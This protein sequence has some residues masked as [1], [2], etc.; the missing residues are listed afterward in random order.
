VTGAARGIGRAAADALRKAGCKVVGLDRE[1]CDVVHDLTD[2]VNILS[3]IP[4]IGEID[5]LVNTAC[6]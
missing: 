3:L 1:A 2:L 6:F 4:R 5:T